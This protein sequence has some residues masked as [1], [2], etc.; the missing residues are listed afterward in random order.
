MPYSTQESQTTGK[1]SRDRRI[2]YVY[3]NLLIALQRRIKV[4]VMH[5]HAERNRERELHIHVTY[6]K[7]QE[8]LM[9]QQHQNISGT[10][11][12]HEQN[13]FYNTLT[14]IS[15]VFG[16]RPGFSLSVVRRWLMLQNGLTKRPECN[17]LLIS[18]K[19]SRLLGPACSWFVLQNHY[20]Q[21][22]SI[23]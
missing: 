9:G 14:T 19:F 4:S 12:Q 20:C 5:K 3:K 2:L 22:P 16:R 1:T 10:L 6:Q 18:V 11:V 23:D 15:V 21:L 17:Q 8:P 13:S 7:V